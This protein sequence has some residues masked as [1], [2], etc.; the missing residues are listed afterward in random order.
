MFFREKAYDAFREM[1]YKIMI[2][3]KKMMLSKN[4]FSHF[5]LDIK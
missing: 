4:F 1:E 5:L 3:K 2:T